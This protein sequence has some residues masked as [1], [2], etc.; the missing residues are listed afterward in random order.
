M[1]VRAIAILGLVSA[2]AFGLLWWIGTGGLGTHW[3]PG[4]VE[5][6]AVPESLVAGRAA[7]Q[8][9]AAAR[10]GVTEPRQI[11]FGDLHVHSTYS[12]DAFMMSLPMMGGDGAHPVADACDFARHCAALDFWSITDHALALTPDAWEETAES[13]RACNAVAAD[14]EAP[15]VSAFLGFEWTQVGTTP[16][17]HWGHKNVILRDTA[18]GATPSHPIASFDPDLMGDAPSPLALGLLGVLQPGQESWDLIRY[19]GGFSGVPPCPAG[20]PVGELPRDCRDYA[21]T[22][23][24]LFARLDEWG[25]EARVIPHGTTWGFYTPQG[26][27]WDKQ[28]AGRQ[29]D[30]ER[31]TLIEVF[32]GHGSSEEYRDWRAVE[33]AGDGSKHCPEPAPAYLPSCWR[34]G[35]IIR[36][37]CAAAGESPATCDERAGEARQ[38]YVDADIT[39][40]RA[41]PGATAADWADS[42]QCRDCFQPAFNYRPGSS[43]Q[44]IMALREAVGTRSFRFGFIASSDNHSAR[45]GTGY[46]EYGRTEMT[47][48]RF[49]SFVDSFL[50]GRDTRQAEPRAVATDVAGFGTDFFGV[51]ESERQASFFLTGGL[52]AV[53]AEG[54]SRG[55]IWDALDRREVY[56]TSGPRILLWFDLENGPGGERLPMGSEVS[57]R[58]APRFR[59]RAAGSLEQ[60]PGCPESSH[61]SLGEERLARLCQGECYHPGDRRRPI[62]RIEVVRIRPRAHAGEEVASLID[63]PWRVLVCPGDAAGCQGEFSDPEFAVGA[64]DSLYYVRAI[65]A[66]AEAVAADPI[67]C[68]RDGA[69]ECVATDPCWRRPENDDCLA[70]TEERAW[71]SPI[72]VDWDG[73]DPQATAPTSPADA[74]GDWNE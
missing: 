64:R 50:G 41:V 53:H 73:G 56:G 49:G 14:P 60:A 12:A 43:V 27:S 37:R 33:I 25:H 5:G 19:F 21:P 58:Q 48:A 16:E 71:S 22:P 26:S 6:L 40:H 11:L 29:H 23:A 51:R 62:M 66:P 38:L 3:G 20:T 47:E 61:R 9:E 17:D 63:D 8:R 57:M 36:E 59:V 39:G 67:G 54:R 69:G 31:Q 46:K 2:L 28:L 42:G 72:F 7:L 68:E 30:P 55:A 24:H 34:A 35:E 18:A 13:I 70:R 15:D 4:Q 45:P 65:E 74:S 10:A 32:S 1:A 44:Y 52:V